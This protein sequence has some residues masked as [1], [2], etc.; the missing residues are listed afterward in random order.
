MQRYVDGIPRLIIRCHHLL[1]QRGNARPRV[2]T[3]CTRFQEM[4]AGRCNTQFLPGQPAHQTCHPPGLFGTLWM[5]VYGSTFWF[6]PTS[7]NLE[8]PLRR[9]EH[10]TGRHQKPNRPKEILKKGTF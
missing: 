4:C 7:S 1:L 8:Q 3:I 10:S 5:E 9:S 2:A 6:L